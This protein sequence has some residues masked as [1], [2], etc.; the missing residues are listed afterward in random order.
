GARRGRPGGTGPAGVPAAGAVCVPESVRGAEPT[1]Y[2]PTVAAGAAD[3]PRHR[4]LSHRTR[5]TR[6]HG[7]GPRPPHSSGD[8]LPEVSAP[9]QRRAVATGGH[10]G[11]AAG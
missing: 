5:G 10:R 4:P 2:D 6:G 1:V 11:V 7:A 9:A 3:H 8:V